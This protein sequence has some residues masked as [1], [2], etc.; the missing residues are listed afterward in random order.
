MDG[1]RIVLVGGGIGGLATAWFLARRGGR[2]VVLLE[3]ERELGAHSSGKNAG[4][5]LTWAREEATMLLALETARFLSD[6]PPGFAPRALADRRGLVLLAAD[7]ASPALAPWAARK[8]PGALERVARAGLRRL[9]PDYEGGAQGALWVRDEG[10]IDT[11]L[12][13][14][15]FARGAR[16]AGASIRT[17]ARVEGF[18][19]DGDALCGVRLAGGEELCAATT[20]L[21]SGGWAGA[22][23]RA[24]G[25][26]LALR[27]T[28]R[29]I[30]VTGPDPRVDPDGPILW[31]EPD[32]YY[33]RPESGGLLISACDQTDVEPDACS[34]DE[35]VRELVAEKTA[36]LLPRHADAEAAHFWAGL[37]TFAADADFLIGPD[38]DVP[39]LFWVA[40]LGGHGMS[41]SAGIGRLAAELLLGAA[42]DDPLAPLVAPARRALQG[43]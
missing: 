8:E 33:A 6:P 28:R 27:P 34:A 16:A 40:A 4:I 10:C 37:R 5:Q 24:A 41:C 12:L 1:E 39:G 14:E 38:P 7:P 26:R 2:E 35:S 42:A 17:G 21:A 23:G 31:S 13:I 32:A 11:A 30:L 18:L 9:L 36:R 29:H 22:L 25:S 19:R 15:A 20:A 43:A 3:R